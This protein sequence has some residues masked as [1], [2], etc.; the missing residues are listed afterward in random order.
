[1]FIQHTVR[2]EVNKTTDVIMMKKYINEGSEMLKGFSGCITFPACIN[3]SHTDRDSPM[4][5]RDIISDVSI[6]VDKK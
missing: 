5:K 3:K 6:A 4:P 1:M 2:I